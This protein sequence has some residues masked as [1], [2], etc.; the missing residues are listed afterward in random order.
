MWTGVV[1]MGIGLTI[2][3]YLAHT[4]FWAVPVLDASGKLTLWIGG[5]ANRNREALEEAIL[6]LAE[7]IEAEL[8]SQKKKRPR[9]TRSLPSLQ[10]SNCN[11]GNS[12]LAHE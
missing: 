7:K 10:G 8:K 1:L 11:G 5:T 4:R 2:V 12:W 6:H 9:T 3:F